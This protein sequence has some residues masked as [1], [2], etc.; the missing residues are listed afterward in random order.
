MALYGATIWVNALTARNRALLR[1]PQRVVA[2]LQA[3]VL[4]EVYRFRVEARARGD[5]PGS[6]EVGR[7]KTLVQQAIIRRWEED[8][9]SPTAGHATVEAICPHLIREVPAQD[10]KAGNNT[11]LPRVWCVYGHGVSHPRSLALECLA[12]GPQRHSLTAIIGGELSLPNVLTA[13]IGSERCWNEM[14]SFC[15]EKKTPKL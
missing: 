10:S 3:E 5:R 8:L 15:E 13:M 11:R 9:G 7:V 6:A 1:R 12:W 4:P 14:A 2:E